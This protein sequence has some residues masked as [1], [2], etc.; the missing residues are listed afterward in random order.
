VCHRPKKLKAIINAK[1]N[2]LKKKVLAKKS[3]D[4]EA[5]LNDLISKLYKAT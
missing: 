1:A 2:S 5:E 3:F 4:L